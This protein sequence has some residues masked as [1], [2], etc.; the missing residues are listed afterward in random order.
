M[1]G[2]QTERHRPDGLRSD[3]STAQ[4]LREIARRGVPLLILVAIVVAIILVATTTG[5]VL[6]R[7]VIFGL[8]NLVA[9]VGLYIFMGNSGILNFG[10]VGFMAIGAYTSALLTMMPAMKHTFLPDLPAW[11]AVTQLPPLAGAFAAGGVAA[12]VGL[13]VGWPI[14]RLS[15]I[16]AAI[17]TMS[18]L[19]ICYIVLGNWNAVTGGQQSL[20]GLPSYVGLW[21]AGLWAI[22]AIVLAFVYQETRWAIA[23]RASR[24]DEVAATASG[25]H[26]VR[27]RLIAFVLSCFVSGIAG[28]LFAH[29]L[30]TL[31]V[32]SFY[33]D[34]TFLLIS[35]LVVGGMR[36]LT[37]ALAGTVCI[38]V[39]T[40]ALR[41]LEVGIRV[42][43]M[44]VTLA[45]APGLGDVV[46]AALMLLIILFRPQGITGGREI[47]LPFNDRPGRRPEHN[48][49]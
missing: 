31:R 36:S 8:V 32:E 24:E 23:L 44:D 35:M 9:V 2:S 20:M 18:L 42:P 7:R 26:V 6:Q 30:G 22:A 10:S 1:M 39:L 49:D 29:F 34:P 41:Q 25:V 17:A 14:M 4:K 37:G 16:G 38:S 15:G 47:S 5:I 48:K 46:L 43:G 21:T 40:E 33:L 12:T 3:M 19:I 27:Q 11:L 28:A 45:T 13:V